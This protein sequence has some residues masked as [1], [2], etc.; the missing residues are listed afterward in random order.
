MSQGLYVNKV[1][2]CGGTDRDGKIDGIRITYSDGST[3]GQGHLSG[4]NAKCQTLNIDVA[5]GERVTEIEMRDSGDGQWLARLRIKTNH[6]D[7]LFISKNYR[8]SLAPVLGVCIY[9]TEY[10]RTGAEL[11]EGIILG[12]AGADEWN[13]RYL[14]FS[15]L[16]QV[17]DENVTDVQSTNLPEPVLED[18]LDV[19]K[20]NPTQTDVVLQGSTLTSLV[21]EAGEGAGERS[22]NLHSSLSFC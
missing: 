11:G 16:Q 7:E 2:V 20:S 15:L 4:N 21:S 6:G 22:R 12:M 13:I 10:K 8:S 14:K 3:A 18:I 1:Y 5:G 9:P 19:P 17:T